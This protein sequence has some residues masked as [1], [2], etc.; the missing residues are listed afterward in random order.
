MKDGLQTVGI[1]TFTNLFFLSSQA[2]SSL[3]K[4]SEADEGIHI[5]CKRRGAGGGK[6]EEV[7]ASLPVG[8]PLTAR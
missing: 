7:A 3:E 1:S 4:D 8:I 6:K 2:Y 5:P